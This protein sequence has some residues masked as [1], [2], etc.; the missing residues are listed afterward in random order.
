MFVHANNFWSWEDA[1]YLCCR[2]FPSKYENL[3]AFLW[4]DP[5]TQVDTCNGIAPN[6]LKH[7]EKAEN[8]SFLRTPYRPQDQLILH[9]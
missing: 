1:S 9:K 8:F 7:F 4:E 6:E 5:T 3:R 2:A